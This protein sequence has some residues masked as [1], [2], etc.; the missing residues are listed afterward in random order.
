[1][2]QN[3]IF[4]FKDKNSDIKRISP[5]DYNHD[6]L[7]V[8]GTLKKNDYK[9]TLN[10]KNVRTSF[11]C[12][13]ESLAGKVSINNRYKLY[14]G[15]GYIA[16]NYFSKVFTEKLPGVPVELQEGG[17]ATFYIIDGTYASFEFSETPKNKN[18]EGLKI[19]NME[20]CQ[21]I[22]IEHNSFLSFDFVTDGIIYA[23]CQEGRITDGELI[24]PAA[25]KVNDILIEE[26]SVGDKVS[27]DVSVTV[28]SI[29]DGNVPI[30][31][32]IAIKQLS[33]LEAIS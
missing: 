26:Y 25:D 19:S 17:I 30:I 16:F 2:S 24:Y 23:T 33:M 20:H 7:T 9:V 21:K 11:I 13:P 27:Y 3:V 12:T 22:V 28:N 15:R 14:G 10:G 6:F 5:Y 1:M 18:F 4:N 8:S 31:N 32:A 29:S